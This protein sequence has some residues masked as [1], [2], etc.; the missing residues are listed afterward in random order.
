MFTRVLLADDD[1]L[2]R[3]VMSL[4]LTKAGLHPV[5]ARDGR[6]ALA[7]L[8]QPDAPRL[9]MIDWVM[10][11]LDGIDVCR[12]L[13]QKPGGA[14]TYIFLVSSRQSEEDILAGFEAG[15]DEFIAK[16]FDPA[17]VIARLQSVK[18]RFEHDI[19]GNTQDVAR[20]LQTATQTGTGE[21]VVRGH[22]HVGRVLIHQGKIAWVQ[23]SN[24][25][26]LNQLLARLGVSEGDARLVL[27]ECRTKKLPFKDT[28]VNWGLVDPEK[29]RASF[30]EEFSRR[31]RTMVT[32]PATIA[33]F[34]P[35]EQSFQ[36]GFSYTLAE[37]EPFASSAWSMVAE[38]PAKPQ[39]SEPPEGA[40]LGEALTELNAIDGLLSASILDQY[41]GLTI[42][43]SGT[44][45]DRG[46]LH[47]KIRLFNFEE[48]EPIEELL[49]VGA[50]RQHILR[51][52]PHQRLLCVTFDR[53]L[54]PNIA[55]I[56]LLV[57]E[58]QQRHANAGQ[59]EASPGG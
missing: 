18:R 31:L 6:E 22:E 15:A 21:V 7:L 39:L 44:V 41:S 37:L 1:P 57:S 33:F 12:L 48:T 50:T 59:T 27:E 40:D 30:Q 54:N 3:R 47:Q 9:A 10:P 26:P 23:L 56:R 4:A 16:P 52:M 11:G 35:G 43:S 45:A 58:W 8:T 38:Q 20:L 14:L 17:V 51:R 53:T 46:L 42:Y 25:M 13:R 55:L 29:L 36:S 28:M 32:L 49:L 2:V 5:I 19:S 34:V 24:G